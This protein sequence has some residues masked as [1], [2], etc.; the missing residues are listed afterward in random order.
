MCRVRL[1][2]SAALNCGP[3][4]EGEWEVSMTF[5][6]QSRQPNRTPHGNVFC[7]S[8]HNGKPNCSFVRTAVG[9]PFNE[10]KR[11]A[12]HLASFT[13]TNGKTNK[14][15]LLERRQ[16]HP[17]CLL[18]KMSLLPVH[19]DRTIEKLFEKPQCTL[20]SIQFLCFDKNSGLWRFPSIHTEAN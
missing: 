10:S 11:S 15:V 16:L 2:E 18:V 14:R 20:S 9:L 19:G 1:V 17:T 12:S 4:D 13:V 3:R 6:C 8:P 7:V 5:I